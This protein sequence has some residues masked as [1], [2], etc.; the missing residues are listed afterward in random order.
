M[1]IR[2]NTELLF[3][4]SVLF[5]GGGARSEKSKFRRNFETRR[6]SPPSYSVDNLTVASP[7]VAML[8]ASLREVQVQ[9]QQQQGEMTQL[10]T[11]N[12][13]L[14][15]RLMSTLA[16]TEANIDPMPGT[17]A[18][19]HPGT[20]VPPHLTQGGVPQGGLSSDAPDR[21]LAASGYSGRY[22][23]KINEPKEFRGGPKTDV[24]EWVKDVKDYIGFHT[25]RGPPLGENEKVLIAAT[26][27]AGDAKI[28]WTAERQ[29]PEKI[30]AADPMHRALNFTLEGFLE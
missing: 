16:A 14:E 20:Q 10:R 8:V 23:I 21:G 18:A 26:W 19:S 24:R 27:L 3:S 30:Q 4:N 28:R 13:Q 2:R 25:L 5:G 22:S 17:T 6:R 11:H 29:K 15:E 1:K 9:L 12:A 7:E